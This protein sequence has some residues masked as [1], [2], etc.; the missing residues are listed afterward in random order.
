MNKVKRL[1][2]LVLAML[3]LASSCGTTPAGGDTTAA[4]GEDTTTA[5]P[6]TELVPAL[7][8]RDFDGRTFRIVGT[9]WATY[10]PLDYID[11]VVDEQNGEVLN[12]AAFARNAAMADKYNCKVEF[13]QLDSAQGLTALQTEVMSGD[14][15]YDIY[16]L[17]GTHAASA[18]SEG[19]L[20]DLSTV[21]NV[22]LDKPWYEKEA[23]DALAAGGKNFIGLSY[24]T[25]NHMN[26]VWTVCFNKQM[27]ADNK[28][29]DP[30]QLVRDGKWT[31]DKAI[32]MASTVAR[33]LNGDTKMDANDLWGIN[34]T[35]DTIMGIVNSC[36]INIAEMSGGK[37][38]LTLGEAK[39]MER[40]QDILTK[41]FNEAY[42]MDTLSRSTMK[43]TDM[44]GQYFA[45]DQVLLLFTA[46]H[47][48]SALRQMDVEFGMLPYPKYSEAEDYTTT[49]AGIFTT[50]TTIPKSVS[51]LDAVGYF[52]EAY[53]YEGWKNVKPAYYDKVLQGKVARDEE[54]KEMLDYIY[55]GITYDA[56]NVYNINK[57]ASNIAG[58][59]AT[60]NTDVA[61]FMGTH[62]PATEAAIAKFNEVK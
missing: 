2:S 49:A 60:L 7:D 42:A 37:M 52:L 32:Q 44:D 27:I 24:V 26:S 38:K 20:T 55:S 41:L 18:V 54:S 43:A 40:L 23:F 57:M 11:I 30:Y 6:E 3:L 56:G 22:D 15:S 62:L 10:A 21:P 58:M 12:D 13:S 29:D 25:T 8:D 45:K 1:P 31:F 53:A 34:H 35:N 9:R 51:D 59:S 19:Y 28:L 48:I 47:L 17:R 5:V 16:L 61:S 36:G 4:S 14:G 33:A 50:L 46:T 39:S